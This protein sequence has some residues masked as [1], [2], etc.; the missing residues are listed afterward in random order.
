MADPSAFQFRVRADQLVPQALLALDDAGAVDVVQMFLHDIEDF[1]T[2]AQEPSAG[3]GVVGGGGDSLWEVDGSGF[4]TPVA[5]PDQFLVDALTGIVSIAASDGN[6]ELTAG[7]AGN[8]FVN[9][10]N[11][12]G[13]QG[14]GDISISALVA[15]SVSIAADADVDVTAQGHFQVLVDGAVTMHSVG[16]TSI[17]SDGQ[18][19]V[20]ADTSV[21]IDAGTYVDIIASTSNVIVD[22]ALLAGVYGTTVEVLG[23]SGALADFGASNGAARLRADNGHL[24]LRAQ[25]G[26]HDIII[27]SPRDIDMT[28]VRYL[29]IVGLPTVTPGG[30]GRV[31]NDA[32]TL[33]IT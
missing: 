6:V 17:Q 13:I 16:N 22:A 25:G 24:T 14:Y 21:N 10:S 29:S 7:G 27:D 4:L 32:G 15:G 1:Y 12:V 18:T 19:Q 2:L 33:K 9:S 11:D 8:V 31:W 23:T 26:T 28:L 30:A 5:S 3:G 20:Q